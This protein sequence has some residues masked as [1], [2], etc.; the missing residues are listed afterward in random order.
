M[1]FLKSPFLWI[2]LSILAVIGHRLMLAAPEKV[3]PVATVPPTIQ[4][5]DSPQQTTS[6][7][8]PIATPPQQTP[9]AAP[10]CK[11]MPRRLPLN[12][13]ALALL[14]RGETVIDLRAPEELNCWQIGTLYALDAPGTDGTHLIKA[15]GRLAFAEQVGTETHLRFLV[16]VSSPIEAELLSPFCGD[17]CDEVVTNYPT[18]NS[19]NAVLL[20]SEAATP[21][22]T[23][24]S[25][26]L[27][28]VSG[29]RQNWASS[30]PW[31]RLASYSGKNLYIHTRNPIHR[32]GGI[33]GILAEAKKRRF[34]R[35]IWVYPSFESS[36]SGFKNWSYVGEGVAELNPAQL[37]ELDSA[38]WLLLTTREMTKPR[39]WQGEFLVF[40]AALPSEAILSPQNLEQLKVGLKPIL[41]ALEKSLGTRKNILV[42]GSGIADPGPRA[43]S[44]LLSSA[45]FSRIF[46]FTSS[47]ERWSK[48]A[49]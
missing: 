10:V 17:I 46:L 6:S 15:I 48:T 47:I 14:W 49:P 9:Q 42:T 13:E 21:N 38:S 3:S 31:D 19:Q 8:T 7:D 23:V 18:A 40:R 22:S 32:S 1:K 27:F 2:V 28:A 20:L 11:T 45:G 43:L 26:G 29:P 37:A 24:V 34:G 39:D 25:P 36:E 35:V 44:N 5:Q 12:S 4:T 33:A 41:T 16:Q 30:A